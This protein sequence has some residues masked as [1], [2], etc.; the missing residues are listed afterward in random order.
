MLSRLDYI[1]GSVFTRRGEG[2]MILNYNKIKFLSIS[3]PFDSIFGPVFFPRHF[4]YFFLLVLFH[5]NEK[6]K[7]ILLTLYKLPLKCFR[8]IMFAII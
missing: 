7:L 3:L 5:S 8:I 2:N 4:L 6:T 1:L